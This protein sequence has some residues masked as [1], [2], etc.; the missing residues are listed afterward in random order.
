[1]PRARSCPRKK[2]AEMAQ[3]SILSILPLA[4]KLG[5]VI[6]LENVWSK[7]L[8]GP[9]EMASFIDTFDS[10]FVKSYFD[11][12][13]C[14]INGYSE[15]WIEV[16]DQRIQRVHMKNFARDGGGGTLANFT[17]SLLEGDANWPAI[18]K[19]LKAIGYNG[20]LTA[21]VIIGDMPNI[22][23]SRCVCQEMKQLIE[24]NA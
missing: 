11:V 4:E 3:R 7:F 1:M 14:L 2:A 10:P 17:A 8:T 21:E 12:G 5:V 24:Q 18:F 9:F 22:E 23:Q 6:A 20:F 19:A 13:N 16:L 15:H